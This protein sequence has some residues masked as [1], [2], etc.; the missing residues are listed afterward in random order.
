MLQETIKGFRAA[1]LFQKILFCVFITGSVLFGLYHLGV[2]KIPQAR[3]RDCSGSESQMVHVS[4]RNNAFVPE[5]V[6]AY[7]CDKLV[8]RNE[9]QE[10]HEPAVGPHPQHSSYPGFDAEKPLAQGETFEFMLNRPG[11][12]SFHDHLHEDIRAT[13]TIE[14]RH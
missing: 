5:H 13:I 7:V 6:Q 10:P 1:T 12:Y 14:I 11:S 9:D 3:A 2:I 8:I 4:I